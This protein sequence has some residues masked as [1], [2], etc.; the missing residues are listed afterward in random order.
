MTGNQIIDKF[1]L[2]S[3]NSTE[4]SA[5]EELDLLN[6]VIQKIAMNRPWEALKTQASGTILNAGGVYYITLP[7]D[8]AYLISNNASTDNSTGTENNA[9]P[10]VIFVGSS[11]TPYQV[12]NF[13]DRRQYLNTIGY[14]YLD[15]ANSRIVFAQDP[16]DD[17]TTY[18]FDYIK[19]PATIVAT[20]TPVFPPA[21]FHEMIAH[22][23]AADEELI[24]KFPRA[25]SY[26]ND[27][28]EKYDG[29]LSDMAY[30]NSMLLQ[31]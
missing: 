21:R 16:S 19:F 5:S 3:D 20:D 27:N 26:A 12:V 6:K 25:N 2:Y 24:E 30:W 9:S 28:L 22:A 11:Y 18:E 29:Y 10:T 8:F 1:N 23:M 31:N 7:A 4:L 15:L 17:G 14:A 13:S